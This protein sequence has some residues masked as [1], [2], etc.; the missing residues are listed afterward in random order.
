MAG[1]CEG[2]GRNFTV[3]DGNLPEK[4]KCH[5]QLMT[6]TGGGKSPLVAFYVECLQDGTFQ[7]ALPDRMNPQKKKGTG[8][9]LMTTQ[10]NYEGLQ[11]KAK[12][13]LGTC[14]R[15]DMLVSRHPGGLF[16]NKE[17]GTGWKRHS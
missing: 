6:V 7:G 13:S 2:D 9:W 4:L 10:A 3:F 16:C 11:R 17:G 15:P 1:G 14:D 8:K 5:E 12:A